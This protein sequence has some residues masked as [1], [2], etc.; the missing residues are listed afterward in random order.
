MDEQHRSADDG[1]HDHIGATAVLLCT[2]CGER[3]AS[4]IDE[5]GDAECAECEIRWLLHTATVDHIA[6][7]AATALAPTVARGRELGLDDHQLAWALQDAIARR[8][9]REAERHHDRDGR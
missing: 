8:L 5:Q 7:E 6:D 1:A 9:L 3:E 2:T 4:G